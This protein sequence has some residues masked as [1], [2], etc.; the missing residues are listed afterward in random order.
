MMKRFYKTV[1][2]EATEQGYQISFDGR[3]VRIQARAVLQVPTEELAEAVRAE[4]QAVEDEILPEEMPMH[5]MMV[6]VVDRVTPQRDAL[7]D[8]LVRY[9]ADDV[10]CYRSADDPDLAA[11]QKQHWDPWLFWASQNCGLVL[12]VTNGV[13]PAMADKR[14]EPVL[15][16]R[17]AALCDEAFGCLYRAATL[18]GSVV[19][20]IAF[21]RASCQRQNCLKPPFWMSCIRTACGAQ[22]VKP[23]AVRQPSGLN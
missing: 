14:A 22:T 12:S 17:F 20:G 6:T 11:R 16:N 7:T 13:M 1:D 21:R 4:W 3:P 2:I 18:S 9:V 23:K 8:E 15:K 19:L 10:L 5:A